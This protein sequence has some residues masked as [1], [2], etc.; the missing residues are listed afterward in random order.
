M[1]V[2]SGIKYTYTLKLNKQTNNLNIFFSKKKKVR[3]NEN[4]SFNKCDNNMESNPSKVV[5]S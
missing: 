5:P 2:D 3:P 1:F 4:Y